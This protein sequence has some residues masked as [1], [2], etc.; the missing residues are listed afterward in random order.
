[1]N[2]IPARISALILVTFFSLGMLVTV[3]QYA[4]FQTNVGFLNQK[5]SYISNSFWLGAFYIHVF[6]CFFCLFAGITQFSK[7][8][9]K[10]QKELHRVLGKAYM[11]NIFFVNAPVGLVLAI[12]A[13]GGIISKSAFVVLDLLW[14]FFTLIALNHAKAKNITRH[15]EFM[16]RSYAL[17]LSAITFR[18]LKPLFI[19]TTSLQAETIYVIDSWLAFVLNL[20]I[21]ELIIYLNRKAN[22][23]RKLQVVNNKQ[24]NTNAKH[25]RN[26]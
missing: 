8:L 15:R 14:F 18:L 6:S 3:S 9:L 12:Y 25:Y 23:S 1:M 19:A 22:L 10:H 13:N 24:E 4:G 5:Q 26:Q 16:I 20:A 2:S 11:G 17:T 7:Y 21:A